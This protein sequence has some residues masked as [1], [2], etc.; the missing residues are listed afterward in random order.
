M[1][2]SSL[3]VTRT[4][5]ARWLAETRRPDAPQLATVAEA[6]H[7]GDR[8]ERH[9]RVAHEVAGALEAELLAIVVDRDARRALEHACEIPLAHA[10]QPGQ[11]TEGVSALGILDEVLLH[12]MNPRAQVRLV[13]EIDAVLVV[14]AV[15][16][17]VDDH[18]ASHFAGDHGTRILLD[19][20]E[21]HVDPRGDP[22]ARD[23]AFVDDE[24]PVADDPGAR[25]PG[26]HL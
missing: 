5:N 26:L 24:Q 14:G 6:A 4:R 15:A 2:A 19:E 11:I 7:C 3:T 20:R 22:G 23:D 12:L 13:V 18:F 1:P 16:T 10:S 25:K 21:R 17:Q 8:I 9:R